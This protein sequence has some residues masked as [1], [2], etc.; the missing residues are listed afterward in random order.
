MKTLRE[1]IGKLFFPAPGSPR[2]MLILPYAI[3]GGLTFLLI[4]GVKILTAKR[5]EAV[6]EAARRLPRSRT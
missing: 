3:L 6:T 4:A 1:R 5:I 2:W